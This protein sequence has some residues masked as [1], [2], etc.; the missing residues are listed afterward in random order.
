MQAF[1]RNPTARD[2]PDNVN[3]QVVLPVT[4][5]PVDAS[6]PV[7]DDLDNSL[8]DGSDDELYSSGSD[9]SD[10]DEE[11]EH[12]RFNQ[13]LEDALGLL[14]NMKDND[15]KSNIKRQLRISPWLYVPPQRCVDWHNGQ[16]KVKVRCCAPH[17]YYDNVTYICTKCESKNTEG[18]GWTHGPRGRWILD[19]EEPYLLCSY[20]YRNIWISTV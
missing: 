14:L 10:S 15:R 1:V 11:R 9:D 17:L 5:D 4:E 16:F 8:S 3:D 12:R 13:E 19:I 20:T 7:H 18:S 6:L 2:G